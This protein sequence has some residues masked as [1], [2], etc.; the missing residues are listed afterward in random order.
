MMKIKILI[1]TDDVNGWFEKFVENL[2][3]Q[4]YKKNSSHGLNVENEM[5]SIDIMFNFPINWRGRRYNSII[6]DKEING[7]EYNFIA[8]FPKGILYTEKFKLL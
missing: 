4:S 3:L 2:N 7:E 6:L 5:F 8:K 1:I